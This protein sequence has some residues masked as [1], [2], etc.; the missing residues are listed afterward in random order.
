VSRPTAA[1]ADAKRATAA[2][3]L[4]LRPGAKADAAA[5]LLQYSQS[6]D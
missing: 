6:G 4:L 5:R 2:A 3:A 1:A